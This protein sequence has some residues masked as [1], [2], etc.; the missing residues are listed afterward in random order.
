M[1]QLAG[2]RVVGERP[3]VSRLFRN[4][5][6]RL[7][8]ALVTYIRRRNSGA[9]ANKGLISSQCSCQLATTAPYW[10]PQCSSNSSR[11][12]AAASTLGAR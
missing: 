12:S 2:S 3:L 7:S 8:M 10:V 1:P 6:F 11:G 4:P 9:K 5:R